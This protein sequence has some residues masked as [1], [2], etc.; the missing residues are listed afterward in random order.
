MT[1]KLLKDQ[2]VDPLR[3]IELELAKRI[4]SRTGKNQLRLADEGTPPERYRRMVDEYYR[5][6]STGR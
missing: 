4:E 1:S 3:G 6:L 5:R 2:V